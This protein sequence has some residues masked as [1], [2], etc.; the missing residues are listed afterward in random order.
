MGPIE[1]AWKGIKPIRHNM[2]NEEFR[3]NY[4]LYKMLIQYYDLNLL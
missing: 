3:D 2:E 1:H 4:N